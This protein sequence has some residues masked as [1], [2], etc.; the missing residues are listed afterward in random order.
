MDTP[1]GADQ[2]FVRHSLDD[3]AARARLQRLM[4]VFVALVRGED[5]KIRAA[6]A[7]HQNADGFD[8]ADPGQA[9]VHERDVGQEL[10]EELDGLLAAA[11]LGNHGHIGRGVDDGRNA[12][13]HDGVIVDNRTLIFAT[14]FM[15]ACSFPRCSSSRSSFIAC[16]QLAPLA[17]LLTARRR[18]RFR[19]TCAVV[20]D[21]H[22]CASRPLR[23][24]PTRS[25]LAQAVGNGA[26]CSN[27]MCRR[28]RR[29]S[30]VAGIR[31]SPLPSLR[32]G[33]S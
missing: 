1:Q 32:R 7:R 29:S 20:I 17:H 16:L 19:R 33:L 11:G 27:R 4:D 10:F 18:S 14:S 8:A 13:T 26:D 31:Y 5:D 12:D 23:R 21:M 28:L 2:G 9:Q 24:A 6:M 3:V 30:R 15:T 25:R 22:A